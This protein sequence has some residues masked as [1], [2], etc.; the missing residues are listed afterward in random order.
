MTALPVTRPRAGALAGGLLMTGI[1]VA[2]LTDAV[3]GTAL[4]LGRG[5]IIGDVY[6][7]PDEFAWLDVGYTAAKFVGFLMASWL[8][9]RVGGRRLL[10]TASLT[11]GAACAVAALTARLD[12]L[13]GCRIAQGLCGGVLLIGG[14][15]VLFRLWDKPFQPLIQAVFAMGAVVAPATLAPALQGWLL[16]SQS[17]TWIFLS[18]VP[19]SLLAAALVLL[20][21]LDLPGTV[22][23]PPLDAVGLILAGVA[24][25]CLTYVLTQGARWDW[26][27]APRIGWAAFVGAAAFAAFIIQQIKAGPARL[28]DMR[29]FASDDFV[30]AFAV[31]FVAGAALFG[32]AYLIPAFAVSV[33]AFTPTDAGLLL[34]PGGGCFIATLLI[35]A[36]L[37]QKRG[38]PPIATAP[39]GILLT[40]T[41]M[42]M[43]AGSTQESGAADMMAALLL[44]GVG[45][46]LLFLS[47]TLIAFTALSGPTLAS[48]ISLF[49]TGRQMGALMGV[50][51]LQTLI[52]HDVAANQA[53]LAANLTPGSPAVAGRLVALTEA[54]VARGMD[55][56]LA[57]RA[58]IALLART[59]GTQSTVLAFETAFGAVALL[60]VAAAP[61]V[62][63]IKIILAKTAPRRAA[64]RNGATT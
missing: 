38:L 23:G 46:G 50:A 24:L 51:A 36:L 43:L 45:L 14:Q 25:A 2:V 59:V 17:W 32:S 34:L 13:V 15:A 41:A 52:D 64:R 62:V 61:V 30:F 19:L 42:W 11:M 56:A 63:A 54:L 31:S 35:A 33:L 12:L 28:I 26:F 29:S 48:G 44:R 39:F 58:A 20:S 5:D 21:D 40:M 37:M 8:L 27:A 47:I 10:I 55:A 4:S 49:N 18:A 57:G 3:A 7:T 9:T 22:E 16:D 6:A 53:V 1:L 60:F